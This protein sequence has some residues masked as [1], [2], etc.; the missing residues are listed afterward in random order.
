MAHTITSVKKNTFLRI[1]TVLRWS[2][3]VGSASIRP[4]VRRS[5]SLCVPPC[6]LAGAWAHGYLR[7][8]VRDS[9]GGEGL[10][11]MS[12][13]S[14]FS[15]HQSQTKHTTEGTSP[16]HSQKSITSGRVLPTRLVHTALSN[17]LQHPATAKQVG[18]GGGR[19]GKGL[20]S[21][22]KLKMHSGQDSALVSV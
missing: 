16:L 22:E 15:V 20:A 11:C 6:W 8:K 10:V 1:H 3:F 2:V 9:T 14:P 5:V 12:F 18:G 17:S 13:P 7:T 21:P 4:S 19:V